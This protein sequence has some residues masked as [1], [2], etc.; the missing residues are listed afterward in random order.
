MIKVTERK[1]ACMYVVVKLSKWFVNTTAQLN[2]GI[3]LIEF[4]CALLTVIN[5]Y[6]LCNTGKNNNVILY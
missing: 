4:A 2:T 5:L 3:V 1:T 6:M